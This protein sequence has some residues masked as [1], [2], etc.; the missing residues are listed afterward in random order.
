MARAVKCRPGSLGASGSALVLACVGVAMTFGVVGPSG[1]SAPSFAGAR[2]YVTAP[3]PSSIAVGDLNGDGKPDLATANPS[4]DTSTDTVSVLLNRGD[5]SFRALQNYRTGRSPLA[6][7]IRDLNGDGKPE[8]VTS[9][10]GAETVSVL[11]NKGNASFQAKRDYSTGNEPRAFAI[12]DLNGDSKPDLAIVNQGRNGTFSVLLNKGDG[13]F[14]ARRAY[15]AR[16]NQPRSVA[17][18]DLNRDGKP[19]LATANDGGTVSV[20]VNK[21]DGSF[22]A[23]RDYATQYGTFWIDIGDLNGDGNPDLA[24]AG[25]VTTRADTHA[26]TVSVLRNRGNGSFEARRDFGAGHYAEYHEN[27]SNALALGDL[28]GDRKPDLAIACCYKALVSVLTNR[29][30]GSFQ[31]KL[32][33][34]TGRP[35]RTRDPPYEWLADRASA[36]SIGDLNGDGKPDLAVAN[37]PSRTVS[38]LINAPGLC[39]VQD[40]RGRMLTGAKR[41]IAR[42]KCRVAQVRR[43]YSKMVKRDRVISQTPK[44]GTVLPKGGKV[45][46]LVSRGRKQ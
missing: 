15:R 11:L 21:G 32:E 31:A 42:A 3:G 14:Q 45:N 5:G 37:Y 2:N 17:I 22:K 20:L 38:V 8:L 34:R 35:W 26:L 25:M 30:D 16:L 39:T 28:N 24:F 18:A 23:R 46:L 33:Y 36:V 12:G 40:A 9:N 29:G 10:Y 43:A 7:A 13:S 27:D 6:L 19:D 44:P 4:T 1:S 41:T